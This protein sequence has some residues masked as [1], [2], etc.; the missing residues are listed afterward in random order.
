MYDVYGVYMHATIV[1]CKQ[2]ATRSAKSNFFAGKCSDGARI[3]ARKRW[4][5]SDAF[6]S[7]YIQT[8]SDPSHGHTH[9]F[10]P[11]QDR[12]RQHSG[13]MSIQSVI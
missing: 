1:A 8:I 7:L 3:K 6:F 9:V 5:F 10:R 11:A 12:D 2:P 13:E 4:T